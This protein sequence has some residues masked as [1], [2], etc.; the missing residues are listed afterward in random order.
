MVEVMLAVAIFAGVIAAI[1]ACWAAV[2]RGTRAALDAAADVQRG[3]ITQRT[4]EDALGTAVLF[5]ENA[6]YYAFYGETDGDY[7][8]LSFVSRMPDSFPGAGMFGDLKMRR[9]TFEVLPGEDQRMQLVMTQAPYLYA[10]NADQQPYSLVLARNVKLFQVLFYDTNAVTGLATG[11]GAGQW[12]DIWPYTNRFPPKIQY[13]LAFDSA[14]KE[15]G[16]APYVISGVVTLPSIGVD[17]TIQSLAAT[18][19]TGGAG[20]AGGRGGPGGRGG[21]GGENRPGGRGQGPGMGPGG[22]FVFD[23]GGSGLY[24]GNRG[25]QGGPGGPGQQQPQRPPQLQPGRTQP[26]PP[27]TR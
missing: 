10:T 3:R 22:D 8:Y 15:S 23:F 26:G 4:I 27:R 24:G 16:A 2:L 12:V 1:Y 11:G 6:R 17:A 5:A 25:G 20:G 19:G 9:V 14:A 7:G 21:Q 18:G 13:A